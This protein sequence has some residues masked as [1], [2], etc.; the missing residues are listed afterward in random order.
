MIPFADWAAALARAAIPTFPVTTATHV[1]V[2]KA[3][4]P[5]LEPVDAVDLIDELVNE[6]LERGRKEQR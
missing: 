1:P 3:E 6:Q 2:A 4:D 5:R